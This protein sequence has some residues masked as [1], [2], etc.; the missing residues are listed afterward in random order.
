[1][2]GARFWADDELT[3]SPTALDESWFYKRLDGDIVEIRRCAA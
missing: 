2:L 3:G 1:M